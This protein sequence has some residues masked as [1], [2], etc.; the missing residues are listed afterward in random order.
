MTRPAMLTMIGVAGCAF[1]FSVTAFILLF[2]RGVRSWAP[3]KRTVIGFGQ[4]VRAGT[5]GPGGPGGP[6]VPQ[7]YGP[8][9]PGQ[10]Q[11]YPPRYQ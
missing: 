7:G 1:V 10:Q 5:P 8:G 3:A 6:P 4:P 11:A 2:M 9:Q